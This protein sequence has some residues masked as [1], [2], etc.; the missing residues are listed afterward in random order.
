MQAASWAALLSMSSD[1]G[2]EWTLVGGQMVLLHQ[3]ERTSPNLALRPD[4]LRMSVDLDVAV[5]VRAGRRQLAHINATLL[6]HGFDQRRAEIAHR[7]ERA[8][9]GVI[10]DVLAPDHLGAHLPR[11]GHGKTF[12]AVGATQALKRTETVLVQ[13]GHQS[14]PVRRPSLVGAILMKIAVARH[15]GGGGNRMS[16]DLG[17]VWRLALLLDDA[18]AADAALTRSERSRIRW[19]TQAA[20]RSRLGAQPAHAADAMRNFL[21]NE[22]A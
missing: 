10:V 3:V 4:D 1:L 14:A 18:D 8:T 2:E 12:Q 6:H 7:Y 9:D 21:G 16:R 15:V 19:A 13:A 20:A 17:D 22:S 11:L 5:N